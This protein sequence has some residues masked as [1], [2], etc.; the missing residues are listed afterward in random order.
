MKLY[1]AA[2]IGLVRIERAIYAAGIRNRLVSFVDTLDRNHLSA[3][4]F[5]I[6]GGGTRP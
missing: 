2:N 1:F 4:R 3:P 5:W 6:V